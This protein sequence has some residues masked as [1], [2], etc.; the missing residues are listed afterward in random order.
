MCG[1]ILLGGILAGVSI[2][3]IL[4]L[5]ALILGAVSAHY[6]S[7]PLNNCQRFEIVILGLPMAAGL[8]FFAAL[9]I[10]HWNP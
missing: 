7:Q 10:R 6:T 9:I 5:F 1:L 2:G 4:S 8:I 3:S